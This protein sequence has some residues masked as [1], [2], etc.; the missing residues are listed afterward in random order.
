MYKF[1][2]SAMLVKVVHSMQFSIWSGNF[3][4]SEIGVFVDAV[5]ARNLP[6]S[7]VRISDTNTLKN[8]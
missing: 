1:I 5:Q 6:S 7:N 8:A 3:P 4:S 2:F